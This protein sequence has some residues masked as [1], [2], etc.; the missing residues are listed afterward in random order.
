MTN[1]TALKECRWCNSNNVELINEPT[2]DRHVVGVDDNNGPVY[3]VHCC[4]CGACG[5]LADW[6]IDAIEKWNRG[7]IPES[8]KVA[9]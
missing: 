9:P 1:P 4:G 7:F 6:A 2:C 5:P 8:Q 3:Y